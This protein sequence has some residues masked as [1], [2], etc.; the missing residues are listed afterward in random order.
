M[1]EWL[2]A[3]RILASTFTSALEIIWISNIT[4][5]RNKVLNRVQVV[6]MLCFIA[7]Q[8]NFVN[9]EVQTALD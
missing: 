6:A 5:T 7:Y 2:S 4:L 1:G 3:A 9:L 8:C